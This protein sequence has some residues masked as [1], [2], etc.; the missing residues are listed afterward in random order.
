VALLARAAQAS[1]GGARMG[2]M[3][4]EARGSQVPQ[5]VLDVS[6][7]HLTTKQRRKAQTLILGRTAT[8]KNIHEY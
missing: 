3:D 6:R 8:M 2:L 5:A 1:L 7:G 4:F